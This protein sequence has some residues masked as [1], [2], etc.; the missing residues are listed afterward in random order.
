MA[1]AVMRGR[2]VRRVWFILTIFLLAGVFPAV[3]QEAES[4]QGIDWIPADFSGVIRLRADNN[5]STLPALGDLVIAAAVMQP[6]RQ[7][8][9]QTQSYDGF[10][11]LT[12]L[13]VE[14]TTF[15]QDIL[16]WLDGE[17]V[18]GY[19][20]F[21]DRLEIL[22]DDVLM[23]LPTVNFFQS[24]SRLGRI[25][26]GQDLPDEQQYRETNIYVGDKTS[27]AIAAD[28]VLIGSTEMI[29][30]ALDVRAGEGERLSDQPAFQAVVESSPEDAV[31]FAYLSGDDALAALSLML[32]GGTDTGPLFSV[33]GEV[34]NAIGDPNALETVVLNTPWEAVSVTL[35]AGLLSQ[36]GVTLATATFYGPE[37]PTL[38]NTIGLN[39]SVLDLIPRN[40]LFAYGGEDVTSELFNVLVMLSMAGYLD[41]MLAAFPIGV[42]DDLVPD[43]PLPEDLREAVTS[44]M[45]VLDETAQFN[46]ET[47]L[48]DHL[49]G[50]YAIVFLPRPNDPT[51][52]LETPFDLLLL[53]EV[54]DGEAALEGA[55]HLA[56][57][58]LGLTFEDD[59]VNDVRVRVAREERTG[60]VVI[61]LGVVDDILIVATGNG[62]ELAHDAGRGDNRLTKDERW[63]RV[64][65]DEIPQLY[66]NLNTVYNTF[67]PA[68]QSQLTGLNLRLVARSWQ[69]ESDVLQVQFKLVIEA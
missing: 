64:T 51:P 56:E 18:L 57:M 13:D 19:R 42:G 37:L 38:S 49:S 27:I 29:Q 48:L 34:L 12:L 11:P 58:V 55:L 59:V 61:R 10:I 25:I 17:I 32:S 28:A 44:F 46:V 36:P 7:I 4:A 14:G 63:Q 16:P 39:S 2:M 45:T 35:D 62:L 50:P 68:F 53:A 40:A 41:S 23:I 5:A 26:Q 30:H 21:D 1:F 3:A 47:D 15:A 54:K 22:P 43:A 52:I 20:Q 6:T 69:M 60:D 33:L 24:A 8:F 9:S 31:V 66:V 67:L 65:R